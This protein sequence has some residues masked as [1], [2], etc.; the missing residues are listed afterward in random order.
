MQ[1]AI[2]AV[3]PRIKVPTA[4]SST[5]VTRPCV[6]LLLGGQH[7]QVRRVRVARLVVFAATSLSASHGSGVGMVCSQLVDS[8]LGCVTLRQFFE[9]V[10]STTV[11]RCSTSFAATTSSIP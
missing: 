9:G 4:A 2:A 1:H 3:A 7:R 11:S 6:N 10:A 8:S 5:Y